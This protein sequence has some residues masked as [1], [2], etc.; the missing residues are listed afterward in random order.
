MLPLPKTWH[1][2]LKKAVN[3]GYLATS[4]VKKIDINKF[5]VIDYR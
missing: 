5:V 2:L 1:L 4:V 3:L